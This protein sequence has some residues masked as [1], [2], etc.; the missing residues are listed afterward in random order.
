MEKDQEK[1][2]NNS[3]LKK[4]SYHYKLKDNIL[5]YNKHRTNVKAE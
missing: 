3:D 1:K 2:R 4:K 5:T